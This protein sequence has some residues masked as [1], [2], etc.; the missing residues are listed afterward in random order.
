MQTWYRVSLRS[1]LS[2]QLSKWVKHLWWEWSSLHWQIGLSCCDSHVK[3]IGG[4]G[5]AP[6]RNPSSPHSQW[7]RRVSLLPQLSLSCHSPPP[8]TSPG[9]SS[10]TP[11]SSPA[12]PAPRSSKPDLP[13]SSEKP[14][15]GSGCSAKETTRLRQEEYSTLGM[16]V[17]SLDKL[18]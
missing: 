1:G 9:S 3:G 17:S 10:L 16:P 14:G 12:P 8:L 15:A 4:Q 18:C 7:E 13:H 5:A 11:T 2:R 6:H